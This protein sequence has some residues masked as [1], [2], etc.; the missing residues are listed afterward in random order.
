MKRK[1]F[2]LFNLAY[3]VASYAAPHHFSQCDVI[4]EGVSIKGMFVNG[5]A[6]EIT[7]NPV[8]ILE[9]NEFDFQR[10]PLSITTVFNNPNAF[11][12]TLTQLLHCSLFMGGPSTL[13]DG[14]KRYLFHRGIEYNSY[15]LDTEEI[16][17]K[18][19]QVAQF[20][21]QELFNTIYDAP[22]DCSLITY[23][24]NQGLDPQQLNASQITFV[25]NDT[26]IN[27]L[28]DKLTEL[29]VF[30]C[31]HVKDA[32]LSDTDSEEAAS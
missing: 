5:E 24:E 23:L 10:A 32:E 21:S 2:L 31:L 12:D 4:V 30:S 3:S 16:R 18:N 27:Q 14:L 20:F 8:D 29:T 19:R 26:P 11:T 6:F 7:H 15:I 28:G 9:T 1:F 17:E 25:L 13:N 22:Q